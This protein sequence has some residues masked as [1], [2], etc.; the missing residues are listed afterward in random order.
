[1]DPVRDLDPVWI[2]QHLSQSSPQAG[3][4]VSGV[5]VRSSSCGR[6]PVF[7]NLVLNLSFRTAVPVN[8]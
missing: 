6:N 4:S 7:L 8:M 2:D 5:P 3:G 1:M